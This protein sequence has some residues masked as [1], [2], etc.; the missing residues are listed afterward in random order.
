MLVG[1]DERR[2]PPAERDHGVMSASRSVVQLLRRLDRP[3]PIRRLSQED[4]THHRAGFI[5]GR[6]HSARA[7]DRDDGRVGKVP[8]AYPMECG[9]EKVRPWS[10]EVARWMLGS[11]LPSV[12]P[13]GMPPLTEMIRKVVEQRVPVWV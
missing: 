6:L 13:V 11:P 10:S 7:R 12:Y 3:S 1:P 9:V 8:R 2:P 4:P 5:P